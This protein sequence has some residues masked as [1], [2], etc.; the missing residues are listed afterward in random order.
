MEQGGWRFNEHYYPDFITNVHIGSIWSPD[1]T[2]THDND[3]EYLKAVRHARAYLRA[4]EGDI[5]FKYLKLKEPS[6]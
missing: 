5:P 6:S 4:K 2:L 3:P 1:G